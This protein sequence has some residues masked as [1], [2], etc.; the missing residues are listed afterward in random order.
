[1]RRGGTHGGRTPR[2]LQGPG[3]RPRE[4]TGGI[5]TRD[6]TADASM[7]YGAQSERWRLAGGGGGRRPFGQCSVP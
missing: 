4:A 6:T 3:C 7:W 2:G 1:M 5:T